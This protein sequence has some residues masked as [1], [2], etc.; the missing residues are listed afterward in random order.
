MRKRGVLFA[1]CGAALSISMQP[2][3]AQ[4]VIPSGESIG[5]VP[6]YAGTGLWGLYYDN[7]DGYSSAQGSTPQASFVTTNACYPDC[8][9]NSFT[10][11]AGGLSAFTNGNATNI[12]FLNVDLPVRTSW[13]NSELDI[14]G[15]MAITQ[16]GTYTF[17]V[18]SDDNTTFSIGGN[19]VQILGGGPQSFSDTF[20]TAGLYPIDLQ[21]FE[22]GGAS[23]LSLTAT[24]PNGSCILGCYDGSIL[25][26][27]LFYSDQE[28][29]GAP[30]PTIGGGWPG[31]LVAILAGGTLIRRRTR[32]HTSTGIA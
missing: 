13:N 12:T 19:V 23:R 1:L 2:A 29:Q 30:A 26:N 14:A 18:G 21:F 27:D 16:P 10:D 5:N 31:M 15:Y 7:L 3:R 22:I 25:P 20:T 32:L 8:L 4:I 17:V 24:D 6:G 9:G 11:S 28:L